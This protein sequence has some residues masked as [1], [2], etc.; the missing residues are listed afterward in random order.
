MTKKKYLFCTK[1]RMFLSEIPL[2]FLLSL[3]IIYNNEVGGLLKLWPLIIADS[4]FMIFIVLY[5][6]RAISISTEEIRAIGL[7]S[8]KDCRTVEK[9][10][11]I[12]FTIRSR[13]R[14]RVE[15]FG[16]D[17]RPAFDWL[18]NENEEEVPKEV[19]LFSEKAVGGKASVT[20]ML[21]FFGTPEEDIE[22]IFAEETFEKDYDTVRIS[23]EIVNEE[24]KVKIRFL[25]T[26]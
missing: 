9:D 17:M 18:K 5:F 25:K 26:V 10:K 21:K 11:T 15:L 14:L 19:N 6:F 3:C 23:S 20:K 13:H 24:K 12:V 2:A 22:R 7:F 8:S 16:K 1:L 4:A